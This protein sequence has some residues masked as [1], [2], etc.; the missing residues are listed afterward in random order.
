M[1]AP[2]VTVTMPAYNSERWIGA[3]ID[4]VLSQTLRELELIVVDDASTDATPDIVAGVADARVT[5]VRLERNA[6]SAAARNRAL[7]MARG[8]FVAMMDSDDVA[9]PHWLAR[10]VA[11][12]RDN[13]ECG[14]RGA[15]VQACGERDGVWTPYADHDH[16][17]ADLLF[18]CGMNHNTVVFRRAE[19]EKLGL[20]YDASFRVAQDY[21][22]WSRCIDRVRFSNAQEVLVNYRIHDRNVSFSRKDDV[23]AVAKVVRCRQLR[24]LGIEPSEQEFETHQTLGEYG[25]SGPRTRAFDVDAVESW[26]LKIRRAN[27]RTGYLSDRALGILLYEYWRRCCKSGARPVDFSV[28]RFLKSDITDAVSMK[29]ILVDTAKMISGRPLYS[30]PR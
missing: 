30:L 10:Q 11:F 22:L 1:S 20:R 6:G 8:E 26:L 27:A 25:P 18:R 13:P 24:K 23:L 4:S 9:L 2:L 29:K 14:L 17:K 19:F 21:E 28:A 12:L 16:I 5:L 15:W 3:A 7:A